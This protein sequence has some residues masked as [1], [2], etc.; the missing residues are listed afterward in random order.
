MPRIPPPVSP[1]A[2]P[3]KPQ[4]HRGNHPGDQPQTI[5]LPRTQVHA[6]AKPP[7]RRGMD[8]L[9]GVPREAIRHECVDAGAPAGFVEVDRLVG[10]EDVAV[11]LEQVFAAEHVVVHD[12]AGGDARAVVPHCLFHHGRQQR[13][14]IQLLERGH[15]IWETVVE[16]GEPRGAR[17]VAYGGEQLRV[18]EDV[19]ESPE[20][21]GKEVEEDAEAV[22]GFE[23]GDVRLWD[24]VFAEDF[25]AHFDELRG[26]GVGVAG[27]VVLEAGDDG[28]ASFVGFGD[29][30]PGGESGEESGCVVGEL[31]GCLLG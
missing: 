12:H 23:A 2:A 3:L 15:A 6:A 13:E 9:P 25:G 21:G 16:G 17:F 4:R 8:L 1:H 30:E 18:G 11:A 22:D 24:A 27:E 31:A 29:E 26:V 7:K 5:R 14:V 20:G 19:P 28:F 10:D